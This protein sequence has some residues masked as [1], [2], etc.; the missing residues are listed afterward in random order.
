MIEEQ[1]EIY[2]L[3]SHNDRSSSSELSEKHG[4]ASCNFNSRISQVF[5]KWKNEHSTRQTFPNRTITILYY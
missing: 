3:P 4:I 1:K 5:M 2:F